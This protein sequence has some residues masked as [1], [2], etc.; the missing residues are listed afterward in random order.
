PMD[1][2]ICGDV[3]FGKT[4]VALRASFCAVMAGKQVLVITPTTLLARQHYHNF[5]ERFSGKWNMASGDMVADSPPTSGAI[6]IKQL[7]RLVST[8]EGKHIRHDLATGQVDIVI[9]TH[10]L[11]HKN[12]AVKNLGLVIVDEEHH[13]G[14]KQ[15]ER[16]KQL[17]QAVHLLTMSATPIP[18]SLQLSLH[19]I[20]DLSLIATPPRGRLAIKTEVQAQEPAALV[21]IIN[22]ELARGGQLFFVAPR[23][24]QLA[25]IQQSLKQLL[26]QLQLAVA[27]GQMP[28]EELDRVMTDFADK[29]Y[30]GLLATNI[31]ES[32]LD[33][34]NVNTIIIFHGDQFGLAQLYQL[35]GRVG[36][37]QQ[38]GY[39]FI[40]YPKGKP[41]TQGARKRLELLDGLSHLGAGFALASHDLD[42]RGAGN[43]LGEEQSGHIKE[44]GVELYQ[45]MVA[46][47]MM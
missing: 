7:S 6:K 30:H 5:V 28:S 24:N 39:C 12:L 47:A 17:A 40:T 16:V 33:L 42:M 27:T 35:R 9:G 38:Q 20:K 21:G 32:G 23:I 46:S 14:V 41:L 15:K 19:G 45:K 34:P 8:A 31:I 26:P 10:G 37:G 29:K 22:N 1:R 44:V 13:F 11:L 3:G 36:R 25:M 43:L 4:E 2:L 18:R